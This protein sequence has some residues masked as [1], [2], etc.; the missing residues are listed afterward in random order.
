VTVPPR[1]NPH[2]STYNPF[3]G[4]NFAFVHGP[5]ELAYHPDP[6]PSKLSALFGT[7]GEAAED[8][9]RYVV[10]H[11]GHRVVYKLIPVSW[12]RAVGGKVE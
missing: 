4:P 8:A 11:G 1:H 5:R 3:T 10:L 6:D 12:H 7:S 9:R 2:R